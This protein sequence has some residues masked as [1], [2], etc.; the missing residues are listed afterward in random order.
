MGK[1]GIICIEDFIYE[2]Y[3]VGEYFK[4]VNNFLWFMKFSFLRGGFCKIIMYF[5]EGGDY[6]NWEDK[7][8]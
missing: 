3:L 2:I 1:Y 8:N 6:G 5:V 4:E 7:I